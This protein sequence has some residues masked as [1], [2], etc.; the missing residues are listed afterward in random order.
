MS[1]DCRAI[2][3]HCRALRTHIMTLNIVPTP[4]AEAVASRGLEARLGVLLGLELHVVK[5][6]VAKL[7]VTTSW[8]VWST[9]IPG[10]T[11]WL[12]LQKRWR[13]RQKADPASHERYKASERR[14][15]QT[16]KQHGSVKLVSMMTCREIRHQRRQWRERQQKC[17]LLG[18]LKAQ[19]DIVDHSKEGHELCEV[20]STVCDQSLSMATPSVSGPT[21]SSSDSRKRGRRKVRIAQG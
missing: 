16:R 10:A 11:C 6:A 8:L 2:T 21:P 15:Y 5:R 14:R 18:S 12:P 13:E 3:S 17:R 1:Q 7:A 9:P 20:P 19:Q 4:L